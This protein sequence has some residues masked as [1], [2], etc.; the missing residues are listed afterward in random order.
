MKTREYVLT[1]IAAICFAFGYILYDEGHKEVATMI[2][3][4]FIGGYMI[5]M[6]IIAVILDN[7]ETKQRKARRNKPIEGGFEI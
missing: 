3:V 2:L 5:T 4:G 6:T 7:K 1:I